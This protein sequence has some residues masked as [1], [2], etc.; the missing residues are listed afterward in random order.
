MDRFFAILNSKGFACIEEDLK[1]LKAK[2]ISPGETIEIIDRKTLK[3]YLGK[4]VRIEK[5][6]A[7][8]EILQELTPNVPKFFI[9][10]YQCVPVKL[11]TFDEIVEKSTQI[12]V[13]EIVP[14]ISKRSFQ[15]ISVIEEKIKRW[16]RIVF[17][18]LK[19][20]GRHKPLKISKPIKLEDIEAEKG[21]LNLFPFER[22]KSKNIYEVLKTSQKPKGVNLIIGPEGGFSKEEAE[23]LKEKG[24]IPVSLGNF[25]LKRET[26]AIVSAGIVYNYSW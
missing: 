2:R 1:H 21:F 18:S 13:S 23:L 3:P 6:R 11:S 12:G 9:K 4:V 8:I 22:E 26:A 20:C 16:K 5:K 19:Q 24:F 14:V 7:E 10:L 15:K 17:E 25:I